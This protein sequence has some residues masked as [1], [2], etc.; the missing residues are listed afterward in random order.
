MVR[1]GHPA[2]DK[3]IP[4]AERKWNIDQTVA[5]HMTDFAAA[6]TEFSATKTMRSSREFLPT[7]DRLVD[8]LSPA[9]HQYR[10]LLPTQ[11]KIVSFA[12]ID[13]DLAKLLERECTR[14]S[15]ATATFGERPG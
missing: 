7:L 12:W 1:L 2:F 3:L 11:A 13:D 6:H 8:S 10:S 15:R 14:N 4:H 5:V 9:R